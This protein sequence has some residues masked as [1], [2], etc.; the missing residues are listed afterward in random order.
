MVEILN[1]CEIDVDMLT[2]MLTSDLGRTVVV[3]V[4]F[5]L[6]LALLIYNYFDKTD[7]IMLCYNRIVVWP[8]CQ[9]AL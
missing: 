9:C 4:Y 3:G 6:F 8:M 1:K 5:L 7:V 2:N